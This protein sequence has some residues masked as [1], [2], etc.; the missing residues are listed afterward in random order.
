[1]HWPLIRMLAAGCHVQAKRGFNKVWARAIRSLPSDKDVDMEE[2]GR[3]RFDFDQVSHDPPV[4]LG[5]IPCVPAPLSFL[6][7]GRMRPLLRFS[8]AASVQEP[9]LAYWRRSPCTRGGCCPCRVADECV[10]C[11]RRGEEDLMSL[12]EKGVLAVVSMSED[13]EIIEQQWPSDMIP[14]ASLEW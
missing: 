4:L 1:M 10:W 5:R 9:R 3:R 14:R 6:L 12:K 8:A 11:G 13:W 7:L 2:D